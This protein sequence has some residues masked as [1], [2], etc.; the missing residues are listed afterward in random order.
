MTRIGRGRQIILLCLLAFG[1]VAMHH[2]P[3]AGHT[4]T[5]PLASTM[6]AEAAMPG[7]GAGHHAPDPGG[8]HDMLHLCLAVL[9]AAAVF[10][11]AWAGFAR[12][13]P[14]IARVRRPAAPRGSP[15]PARPPD[16]R[17]RL[18]LDA[19]CVLRV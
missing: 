4:T 2:V 15:G 19:L 12:Q 8:A 1:V 11:L 10:L 18:V 13:R 9:A 3:A 6:S 16:R 17:G 7:M 5:V 14:A